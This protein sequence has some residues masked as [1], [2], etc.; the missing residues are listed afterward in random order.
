MTSYFFISWSASR[1]LI[2]RKLFTNCSG[3][4][5]KIHSKRYVQEA[6][7]AVTWCVLLEK[8][9]LK[10]S[11]NSQ[12]N[13]CTRVSFL[14]KL[15][16]EACNFIKKETLAQVWISCEFCEISKNTFFTERLWATASQAMLN[17][18][19]I[20]EASTSY[21][22]PQCQHHVY[23]KTSMTDIRK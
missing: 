18:T 19:F 11:Q 20:I 15:K 21:L 1:N 5:K 10:I 2:L 8:M 23:S 13:I 22:M 3:N 14:I 17:I 12:E 6:T 16:A 9:F 7:E 4:F